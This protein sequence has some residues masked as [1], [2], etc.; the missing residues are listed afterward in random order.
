MSAAFWVVIV[1]TEVAMRN[2]MHDRLSDAYGP[3]W[4][5]DQSILD[6]R[7]LKA[8]REAKRRAARG[9]PA[10]ATPTP[11]KV[12][13]EMSF[14]VWVALLDRGGRSTVAGQRLLYHDTLWLPALQHAFPAGPGHQRRTNRGLRTVQSLR[15]RIGHHEKI[16]KEP[17][18]D[19]QLTLADLHDHCIDVTGWISAEAATWATSI[20]RVPELL[21]RRPSSA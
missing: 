19:T 2:A 16:F 13:S 15:N 7:S 5:D 17:F 11:G 8:I 9:L 14:G 3:T 12:V 21:T 4:Y 10:G 18:K 1:V 6:D 20:S